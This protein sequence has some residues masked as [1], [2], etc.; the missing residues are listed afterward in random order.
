M[1][2]HKFNIGP[3]MKVFEDKK[4]R[5]KTMASQFD[6]PDGTRGVFSITHVSKGDWNPFDDLDSILINFK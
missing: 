5:V 6:F 3:K 2:S 4:T 1:T